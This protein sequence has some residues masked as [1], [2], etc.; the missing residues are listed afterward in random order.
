MFIISIIGQFLDVVQSRVAITVLV[1]MVVIQKVDCYLL[2]CGSDLHCRE[3]H[4]SHRAIG[5]LVQARCTFFQS[6]TLSAVTF[7]GVQVVVTA[8]AASLLVDFSDKLGEDIFDGAPTTIA[9]LVFLS[10]LAGTLGIHFI[11]AIFAVYDLLES[12]II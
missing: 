12:L 5:V 11:F 2:R 3:M 10:R 1:L 4:C 8:L 9:T 7:R 6:L